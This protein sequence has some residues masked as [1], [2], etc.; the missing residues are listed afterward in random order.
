[1]AKSKWRESKQWQKMKIMP[2]YLINVKS[3]HKRAYKIE[4]M[5][6]KIKK[7]NIFDEGCDP[8]IK[9]GCP[10]FIVKIGV[11]QLIPSQE[12]LSLKLQL[13]LG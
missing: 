9:M 13:L 12:K 6:S 10:L 3:F 4:K 7:L 2:I 5:P 8:K 1:M 11:N